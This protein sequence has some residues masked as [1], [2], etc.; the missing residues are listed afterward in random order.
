MGRNNANAIGQNYK[1]YS[2]PGSDCSSLTRNSGVEIQK[3]GEQ[4][5]L[6]YHGISYMGDQTTGASTFIDGAAVQMINYETQTTTDYV[7]KVAKGRLNKMTKRNTNMGD[8]T[9]VPLYFW[10][11]ETSTNQQI[12]WDGA[13]LK[14]T[15]QEESG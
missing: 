1:L 5:Y 7:L 2:A 8:L 4:A 3:E 12:K 13:S 14:V 10:N 15:G 6:H 9:G 11:E